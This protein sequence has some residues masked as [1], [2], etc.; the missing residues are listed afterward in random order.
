MPTST[1]SNMVPPASQP[2]R[3]TQM[4]VSPDADPAAALQVLKEPS[5]VQLI[6]FVGAESRAGIVA[7]A[8]RT[9]GHRVSITRP[10]PAGVDISPATTLPRI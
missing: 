4:F 7:V 5:H 8:L 1:T 2:L 10:L 3:R 9:A 6:P